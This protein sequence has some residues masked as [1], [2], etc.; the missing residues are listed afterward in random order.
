MK[1]A[2]V[3]LDQAAQ[4]IPQR[5][6]ITLFTEKPIDRGNIMN[7]RIKIRKRDLEKEK[8]RRHAIAALIEQLG[9]ILPLTW[10]PE[11][12]TKKNILQTTVEFLT[13]IQACFENNV[14]KNF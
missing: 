3:P 4:T 14:I 10:K 5:E 2:L 7:Q 12:K 1:Q 13:M 9:Q 11:Y 8:Q 6:E